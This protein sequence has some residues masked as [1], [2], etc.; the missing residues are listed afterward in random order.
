MQEKERIC[1]PSLACCRPLGDRV[2]V[3]LDE[4]KTQSE[5]GILLPD[6]AVNSDPPGHGTVIRVG[7]GRVFQGG[8]CD[9]LMLPKDG[10]VPMQVKVGDRVIFSRFSATSAGADE[11]HVILREDDIMGVLEY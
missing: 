5:G 9:P 7:P 3:R 6:T 11:T 4:K 2:V 10:R 8:Q 1:M